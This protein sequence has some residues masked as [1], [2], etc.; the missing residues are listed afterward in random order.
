[1]VFVRQPLKTLFEA[2]GSSLSMRRNDNLYSLENTIE[3]LMNPL[4]NTKM[5]YL[6]KSTFSISKFKI[7]A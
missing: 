1:M 2:Q 5:V 3:N 7:Q 6:F 4:Q